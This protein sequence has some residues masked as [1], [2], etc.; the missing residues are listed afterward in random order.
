LPIT[1]A[2]LVAQISVNNADQAKNQILGVGMA[3]EGAG[4]KFGL[5]GTAAVAGAALLVGFGIKSTQMAADYQQSM[6]KVQALTGASTDQMKQFDAGLKQLSMDTGVAPKQLSDGLYNVISAGYQGKD[7]MTVLGLAT[8]DAVIGMT[9]A[10]T[11]TDALTNVMAQFNIKAADATRVNGEMLDTVT[12]GKSTFEQYATTIVKSASAASQ[13]HVSMETM[14]AAFATMTSSGIKSAQASTD[15]QASLKV[16]DGNIGT[17]TKSLNKSGIAFDETKFNA[18]DYGHQVVYLNDA[19]QQANEKHVKVTGVT[20][21]A[22]QA[23]QTIAGHIDT[24]NKDLA[25]LSDKQAMADKT[26]QA[27][28]IT[29]QGFNVSMERLKATASVVMI[30]L[31]QKILPIAT[32][33]VNLLNNAFQQVEPIIANVGNTFKSLNLSGV[34]NSFKQFEGPLQNVGNLLKG[35]FSREFKDIGKDAQQVGSW[36]Q[37]SVIPALKQ[38]APGFED[39]GKTLLNTVAPAFIKIRGISFDVIQHAFEKFAPI[40]EKI[41]PPLIKFEG[42]LAEGVSKAFQF[43]MPYILQASQAIGKFADEIIDRVV[44]IINNF[45]AGIIPLLTMFYNMW[46]T[47][48]PGVSSI[49]QGV[50]DEVVGIIKIAWAIVTGIIKIGLDLLSG[51][52]KQAWTDML[53]MFKGIWDGMKSMLSGA[54]GIIKGIFM[55]MVEEIVGFF[56]WLW[57]Q[58]VGHSIIPDMINGIVSWFEQLPGRAMAFVSNLVTNITNTLGGLGAKALGWAGDMISQFVQGIENGITS[59]GNAASKIAS[60]ISS[61]LHFSKPDVGPLVDVDNWMP[62]FGDLLAKGINDQIGKVSH[63]SLNLASTMN[64]NLNPN[65]GM[66]ALPAGANMIPASISQ[67]ASGGGSNQPIIINVH[68]AGHNVAQAILPDI[69]SSVRHTTGMWGQ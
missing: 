24:Y 52:W 12:L 16:M 33:G 69:V 58:L 59:I 68:V 48:W 66:P 9:D 39:L 56:T 37:S 14:N 54:W 63:A 35:E 21:Q 45:I 32:A 44:P 29:Q 43:I 2:Q 25:T 62:D 10:K 18:M 7:A 60:A 34:A 4:S 64:M 22:A 6:N 55:V 19:L 1:A 38:A 28:A 20:L 61:H 17:V 50:W 46:K 41:V 26:Q 13:F 51:N 5:L 8:K 11:T 67:A 36:F 47:I 31:G 27:W 57:N 65:A 30:D 53:D 42:I 40:I 3:V 15:F 49:L 23:I